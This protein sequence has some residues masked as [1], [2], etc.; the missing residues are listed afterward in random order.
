MSKLK[1]IDDLRQ[2]TLEQGKMTKTTNDPFLYKGGVPQINCLACDQNI[3]V[4]KIEHL[5]DEA[6]TQ[7]KRSSPKHTDKLFPRRSTNPKIQKMN[8]VMEESMLKKKQCAQKI[9][10]NKINLEKE[11]ARAESEIK[12]SNSLSMGEMNV[13]INRLTGGFKKGMI[14]GKI[15][16]SRQDKKKET[17]FGEK[18]IMDT[19]EDSV[20]KEPQGNF[21]GFNK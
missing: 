7:G 6:K 14:G 2:V 16:T 9:F 10:D 4:N 17:V 12:H 3:S 18:V 1:Q 21:F 13:E 19:Q 5:M 20:T 8:H 11:I 15:H